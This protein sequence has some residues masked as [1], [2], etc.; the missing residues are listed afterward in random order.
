MIVMGLDEAGRGSVLGPMVV[1][2]FVVEEPRVV[3]VIATGATDSKKLSRKRRESLIATLS[4]IGTADVREISASAIDAGNLNALEEDVFVELIRAHRP[5]KV[6]IDAPCHPAGIPAFERRLL[7]RLDHT[8]VLVV[9]PKADLNHP[10]CSAASIFGKVHRDHCIDALRAL[11]SVGSGYPSDPKTRAWIQ[12]WMERGEP[13]PDC[14]RT[15]WGTIEA[16]AQEMS[17]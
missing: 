3:D 7:S 15:R 12:G 2:A 11:G 9:E 16:L 13:F 17:S 6:I 8:P 4:A 5:D 1:G 14:V 10:P